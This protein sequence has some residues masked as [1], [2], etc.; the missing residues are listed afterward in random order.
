MWIDVIHYELLVFSLR[1]FK[2]LFNSFFDLNSYKAEL[3]HL[4]ISKPTK[5][6]ELRNHYDSWL[7]LNVPHLSSCEMLNYRSSKQKNLNKLVP[8]SAQY[9]LKNHFYPQFDLSIKPSLEDKVRL[10]YR[11]LA[12]LFPIDLFLPSTGIPL[13]VLVGWTWE[14]ILW[15]IRFVTWPLR[16]VSF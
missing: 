14:I 11:K 9:R 3:F 16:A 2:F 12:N 15:T 13:E 5:H 6:N 10:R 7:M 4:M 8:E 1:H